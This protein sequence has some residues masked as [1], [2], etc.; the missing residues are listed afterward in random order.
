MKKTI[1][2]LGV[3]FA[4]KFVSFMPLIHV[5][6]VETDYVYDN[7]QDKKMKMEV[8]V[9][10]YDQALQ[11]VIDNSLAI[12]DI[13]DKLRN[14]HIELRDFA[15]EIEMQFFNTRTTFCTIAN[16][17]TM[18][19]NI[20]DYV[21]RLR[22]RVQE[23][24]NNRESDF[25]RPGRQARN[26]L[27]E[28]ERY[29]ES[30]RLH[31]LQTELEMEQTLRRVIVNISDYDLRINVLQSELDLAKE[32]LLRTT[33]LHELGLISIREFNNA[34]HSLAQGCTGMEELIR[35]RN[36]ARQGLNYLLG[37][38]LYQYTV[39]E[40]DRELMK[41]SLGIVEHIDSVISQTVAIRQ[42]QLELDTALGERWVFTGN[43]RYI[44][45]TESE[46]RRARTTTGG[47]EITRLRESIALQ[48]AV[49]RA[50]RSHEQVIR[51]MEA[52]IIHGLND[53]EGLLA[54]ESALRRELAQA[55]AT[56]DVTMISIDLGHAT[57]LDIETVQLAII[58]VE[59]D[60]E[61]LH[62]SMWMLT[63][64]LENPDLL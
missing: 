22:S 24:E 11:M 28:F 2:L 17:A 59:H 23:W 27:D 20:T 4:I 34:E 62:N 35:N 56:L 6:G 21:R 31:L 55:K 41:L 48:D 44:R 38:P 32:N 53:F 12:Q 5:H 49:E 1:L 26:S 16:V 61:R 40:F 29:I 33:L 30:L 14:M 47:V 7:K 51:T 9:L 60:I 15:L 63:F 37:L 19:R 3:I 52:A 18:E 57:R 43:N 42:S 54:F 64:I 45:I 50:E 8:V 25:R 46:R 13:Y 36:A 58:K 10:T 39:V